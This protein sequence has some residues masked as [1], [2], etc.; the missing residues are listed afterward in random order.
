ML[1]QIFGSE[2]VT[3]GECHQAAGELGRGMVDVS[4]LAR[5]IDDGRGRKQG[6]ASRALHVFATFATNSAVHGNMEV[7]HNGILEP[8]FKSDKDL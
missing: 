2:H 7:W 8:L 5:K 6:E 4:Q 1:I 3:A